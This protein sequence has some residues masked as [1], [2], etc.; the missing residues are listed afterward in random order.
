M[1]YSNAWNEATPAGSAAANTIDDNLRQIKLD[2]R[3]RVNS[4]IGAAIGTALADPVV[5]AGTDLTS[6]KSVNDTQSTNITTLQGLTGS[7]N[8]SLWLPWNVGFVEDLVVTFGSGTVSTKYSTAG[9]LYYGGILDANQ[10]YISPLD[11]ALELPVGVT[12]TGVIGYFNRPSSSTAN[13]TLTLYSLSNTG[14]RGAIASVSG[15]TGSTGTFNV[16]LGTLSTTTVV[17][18]G[19]FVRVTFTQQSA[20][21]DPQFFGLKILYTSPDTTKRI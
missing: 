17:D 14:T 16:S 19:Y 18:V 2:L 11:F 3:E 1:S 6:L 4:M 13:G 21:A 7:Q 10:P 15:S 12:I 9:G 20:I 5:P 8:L